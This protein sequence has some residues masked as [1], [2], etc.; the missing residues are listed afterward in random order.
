AKNKTMHRNFMGYTTHH[1][2]LMIGLGASAIG[3]TWTAFA[4]NI[5]AVEAYQKAVSEGRFPIMKG[6]VLDEEEKAVRSIIL[7]L[8]C[9]GEMRRDHHNKTLKSAQDGFTN[10]KPLEDDKLLKIEN[11]VIRV[12]ELGK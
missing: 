8:M 2:E 7:D 9:R 5:R 4:Q 10:C 12:T 1:T 3:D 11:D 6:H